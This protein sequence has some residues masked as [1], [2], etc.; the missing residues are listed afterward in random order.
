MDTPAA[1]NAP[2]CQLP[3]H[4]RT[5]ARFVMIG[6]ALLLAALCLPTVRAQGK[7]GPVY[8]QAR[9]AIEA[10]ALTSM[11]VREL[12]VFKDGHAF[13]LHESEVP[14]EP[15]GDVLLNTLPTPV[16]GTFWAY[17]ADAQAK[18]TGVVAGRRKVKS[19]RSA[20][21]VRELLDANPG[22]AVRITEYDVPPYEATIV[23]I[24]RPTV[25]PNA[26]SVAGEEGDARQSPQ[27][28]A[29]PAGPAAEIILLKTQEGVR[30]VRLD[31]IRDVTFR[32]ELNAQIPFEE[33]R[34][35]LTLRLDWGGR[36]PAASAKVG[37][38]YLQRGVRWIP[39]YKIDIDGAGHAHVKLQATLINELMDLQGVTA[40]L[41]I[42][43]PSFYFKDT[44]DPLALQETAAQLGQ[45]FA[46]QQREPYQQQ[47]MAYAFSN[48]LMTQTARMNEMYAPVAAA[49]VH[50]ADDPE[51]TGASRSE[52][53][54]VFTVPNITLARGERMVVP[55]AE[56][57]LTYEDIFALDVTFAPPPEMERNYNNDQALQL[58]RLMQAPRVMHR[59]R[60]RNDSRYPLTTAPALVLRDGRLLAQ[61]LMTYTAVGARTDLDVTPAVDVAVQKSDAETSRTPN[62]VRWN[63]DD[64]GRVDLA[65]KLTLTNHR[66]TAVR[67][68]V[69]RHVL[70]AVE[71]ADHDGKIEKANM[72]ED[73]RAGV[74]RDYP[75]WWRWYNWPWWWYRFN[76]IGRI[77]WTLDLPAGESV[78]LSYAWYYY[79]R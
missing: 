38:V 33:E 36:P 46:T 57:D 14:T 16:I 5:P 29:P 39:S 10:S 61:S 17:S 23:G 68:E 70:G 2:S 13:V 27:A 75:Y 54:F 45:Y 35:L 28:A 49:N 24:P 50:D 63:G 31:R 34:K 1:L 74:S 11:P 76:G 67:L 44:L 65:G 20:L 51:I 77:T 19:E 64:Y 55:V 3:P 62:A 18:L 41:V 56:F 8:P 60:L 69:T 79:W 26:A 12:A 40:N 22:A 58:A 47:Q 42:G 37:M 72:F 73:T 25:D 52:D 15:G 43:V 32:T 48:A 66:S 6:L 53:L 30:T 7:G 9:A 4:C 21:S 59:I 78:D 71:S